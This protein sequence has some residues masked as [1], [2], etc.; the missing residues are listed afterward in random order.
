M[1]SITSTLE[2]GTVWTT[3]CRS[4]KRTVRTVKASTV[5]ALLAT[6]TTSPT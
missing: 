4:L 5:P 6:R 2:N 3:P 1:F